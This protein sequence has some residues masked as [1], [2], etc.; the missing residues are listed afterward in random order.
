MYVDSHAHLTS[1]ELYPDIDQILERAKAG[2]IEQ[3]INICTDAITLRRGLL[4]QKKSSMIRN[5]AA[6]TPHDVETLGE[7]VFQ[8]IKDAALTSSLSAVGETGLDYHYLHSSKNLQLQ[9]LNR[10]IDLALAADL[11]IVIHCR[12]AFSDL[13]NEFDK[14][15]SL[16]VVL[17]CFTGTL[18]EAKEVIKRGWFLSLSGIVTFKKAEALKEVAKWVPLSQLFIE[19]DAPYLAP[20]SRRGKVNEPLFIEETAACIAALKGLPLNELAEATKQNALRFFK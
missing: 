6:I 14:R 9:S 15:P 11:P 13:F 3:I 19:T 10:H 8:E 4:L 2:G 12:E 1:D 18:V 7:D 5:T 17:H 16:K 20:L